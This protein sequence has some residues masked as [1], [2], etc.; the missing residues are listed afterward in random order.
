MNE[1]DLNG[2]Q[3]KRWIVNLCKYKLSGD[4]S[5]IVAKGLNYAVAPDKVPT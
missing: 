2:T 4:Q 5:G 3:L 1:L